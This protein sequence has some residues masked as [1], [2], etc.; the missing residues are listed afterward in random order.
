MR[1]SACAA[2][3]GRAN[4]IAIATSRC[5]GFMDAPSGSWIGTVGQLPRPSSRSTRE[6]VGEALAQQ[7]LL[8]LAHG[9]ARQLVD[10]IVS[11]RLLEARD[12]VANGGADRLGV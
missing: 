3:S 2:A 11:P 5:S 10:D 8:D 12:A 1:V 6:R 9:V 7:V 4:A